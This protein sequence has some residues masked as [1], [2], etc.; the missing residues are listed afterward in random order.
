MLRYLWMLSSLFNVLFDLGKDSKRKEERNNSQPN[1]QD[2]VSM[3]ELE[4]QVDG[5][6][7]LVRIR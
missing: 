6:L 2:N 4:P 5:H 3:P 1:S 7:Y